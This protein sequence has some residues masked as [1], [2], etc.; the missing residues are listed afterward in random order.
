MDKVKVW[1]LP[2]R[3]GHWSLVIAFTVA[4]LS[5]DSEHWRLVH[6]VAGYVMAGVLVFRIF[7][8]LAGSR[9]ARFSS[10]LFSPRDAAAYLKGLLKGEGRHWVGHN[11]AGS[12]AIYG[13]ILLGFSVILS[14]WAAYA[15][16]GPEEL[17]DVHEVLVNVMLGLV[18]LHV[19]G[20]IASSLLHRE[21][22]IRGMV[23][24]YKRGHPEEAIPGMRAAWLLLLF[25]CMIAAGW[26]G[27]VS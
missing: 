8:G 6:V 2:T 23:T 4:W 12:Y 14:G 3:V 26:Y 11:P 24:G 20:A 7:W 16:V 25:G 18:G 22:L 21:N 10:F 17:D 1:D 15:E 9:H 27:F 13:L 5:G 19:T